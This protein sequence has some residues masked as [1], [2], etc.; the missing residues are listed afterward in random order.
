M[1][2][3][4]YPIWLDKDVYIIGGGRSLKENNFDWDVL[5]NKKTIGCNDAYLLGVDICKI[6]TFGDKPWFNH[7]Q[8]RLKGYEG[9]V[10]TSHPFFSKTNE[11]PWVSYIKRY[12]SGIHKDGLGWNANTGFNAI[13]LA[14]LLG[15][16]NIYLLGFDMH[17]GRDGKANWHD[18][19][20][21]TPEKSVYR[22]FLF[23]QQIINRDITK[24][25]PGS[26][27]YNI[28]DDSDLV[29]FPQIGVKE[30]FGWQ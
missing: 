29:V 21:D 20:I 15:A 8:E 22:K 23:Y 17:L 18:D 6:C 1:K 25:F 3:P 30:Y 19:N 13:N 28:N 26:K 5:K 9:L 27:V 14:L 10:Y 12:D 24:K 7:H 4:I 11:Y 2:S 16:S